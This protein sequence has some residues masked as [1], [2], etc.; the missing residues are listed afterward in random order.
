MIDNG[1]SKEDYI[2]VPGE[3]MKALS[4]SGVF[5]LVSEITGKSV[6]CAS[7]GLASLASCLGE[8][9]VSPRMGSFLPHSSRWAFTYFGAWLSLG[10][11]RHKVSSWW[12][13]LTL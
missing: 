8:H 9:W 4:P 13:G 5:I 2:P 12:A 1:L 10:F 6:G 7:P 11:P 3:V